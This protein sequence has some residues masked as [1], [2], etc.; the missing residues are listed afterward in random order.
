[1][2]WIAIL[3]LLVKENGLS[4]KDLHVTQYCAQNTAKLYIKVALKIPIRIEALFLRA[5]NK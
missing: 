1:M 5:P 2:A 3:S 4:S